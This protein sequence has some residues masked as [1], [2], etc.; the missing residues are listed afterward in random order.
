MPSVLVRLF[1]LVALWMSLM[2]SSFA[3]DYLKRTFTD[4]AQSMPYR[5]LVPPGYDKAQKYPLLLFFHG[6]GERGTDNEEQLKFPPTAIFATADFQKA[7]P[8]FVLVPQ[9]PQDQKWVD[10]PWDATSGVRPAEPSASMQLALGILDAVEAEFS[11]D[12][13]RVYVAGHSMGGYA[14]W[15]CVTRFPN[16]FAAAVPCCGGGDESTV[17]KEVTQ[18]PLWAFHS[19]DDPIVP[20]VRTRNMIEAL[21]KAGGAPKYIEYTN[22]G[23]L[24]WARAFYEPGLFDWLFAQS[25]AQRG[26]EHD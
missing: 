5:L 16:R 24:I 6:A 9:C 3:N 21:R 23:H 11:I 25:L 26:L 2:P 4:G 12:R 20:V 13:D 22:A 10:M 18:V 1:L 7:H 8:C 17:T 19:A 15:D 14:T